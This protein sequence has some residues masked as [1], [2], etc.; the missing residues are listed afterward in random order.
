VADDTLATNKD[1]RGSAEDL[2]AWTGLSIHTIVDY[3]KRGIFKRLAPKVF[4]LRTCNLAYIEILRNSA[5]GRGGPNEEARARLT[6]AQAARAEAQAGELEGRLADVDALESIYV[7]RFRNQK[8]M[9]LALPS[10][11]AGLV[12]TLDR[13]TIAIFDR[14]IRALIEEMQSARSERPDG[15]VAGEGSGATA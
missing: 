3:A 11:M 9:M 5:S 4:A 8:A 1:Y 10:R 12:P 14:E 15:R 7:G 6:R 2:A 13:E